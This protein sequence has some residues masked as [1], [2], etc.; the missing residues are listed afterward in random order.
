MPDETLKI[1][2]STSY[3]TSYSEN[4]TPVVGSSYLIWALKIKQY[5]FITY[6]GVVLTGETFKID[7]C[8]APFMRSSHRDLLKYMAKHWSTLK[9]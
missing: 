7:L 9:R 3:H 1:I 8:S 5:V 4:E 2:L 6:L